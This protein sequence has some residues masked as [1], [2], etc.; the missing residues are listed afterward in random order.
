MDGAFLNI[1]SDD[2]Q[3]LVQRYYAVYRDAQ[4][5]GVCAV[6]LLG[7][8][9]RAVRVQLRGT[10]EAW[11]EAHCPFS[12]RTA[13]NF[14]SAVERFPAIAAYV[15]E[16]RGAIESGALE[17]AHAELV[18]R[19]EALP[20]TLFYYAAD[21][22]AAALAGDQPT[23]IATALIVNTLP[24]ARLNPADVAD[25]R[26]IVATALHTGALSDSEGEAMPFA[27]ALQAEVAETIYERMMRHRMHVREARA[28]PSRAYVRLPLDDPERAAQIILSSYDADAVARIVRLLTNPQS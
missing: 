21:V 19:L 8:I 25:L 12:V 4:A 3:S 27:A 1:T 7:V 16:L 24:E 17:G 23:A 2:A 18:S 11:V 26:E 6:F 28:Q 15:W 13:R 22:D 14:I 10:W 20:R 9:L 5:R